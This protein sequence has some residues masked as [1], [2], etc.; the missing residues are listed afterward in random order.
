MQ[1]RNFAAAT[2]GYSVVVSR[3]LAE[4]SEQDLKHAE[5]FFEY[6]QGQSSDVLDLNQFDV[7]L[8]CD[9]EEYTPEI[10]NAVIAEE[11]HLAEI[12]K[13]EGYNKLYWNISIRAHD[14]TELRDRLLD[15]SLFGHT[16]DTSIIEKNRKDCICTVCGY[17]HRDLAN[18][19]HDFPEECPACGAPRGLFVRRWVHSGWE[20]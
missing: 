9:A 18:G 10:L 15:G 19:S 20:A 3:M 4:I 14:L 7:D 6:A 2:A 5:M 17:W 8:Q 13:K 11:R 12:F 16:V 1:Y